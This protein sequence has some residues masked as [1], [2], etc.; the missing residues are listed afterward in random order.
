M[1]RGGEVGKTSPYG[2]IKDKTYRTHAILIVAIL[3]DTDARKNQER[4]HS[5]FFQGYK[6]E[7]S[8]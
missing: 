5:Y 6:L 8:Q 1:E 7:L 3:L 2:Y 4:P